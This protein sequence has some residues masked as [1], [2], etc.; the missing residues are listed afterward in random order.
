MKIILSRKGFDSG[1][2][3]IP[4]PIL[5]DGTMLSMPIPSLQ[6]G[7]RYNELKCTEN[8]SYQNI[9]EQLAVSNIKLEG[10]GSFDISSLDCHLDPDIRYETYDRKEGW[11]GI[12]GQAGS[13]L[14]HLE[15]NQVEKGDVFLFFGWFRHTVEDNGKLKYDRKCKGFH[16]IYGYL[17]VDE[18]KKI[19]S[20]E[21][22]EWALYHP[23]VRRGSSAKES[24]ALYISS[25]RLTILSNKQGYG[26]F[27]Y[28]ERLKLTKNGM[29][30]SRWILP[31]F[32]REY[33]ISYHSDQ[34]WKDGYFQSAAKGQEFVID[35]DE[36]LSKWL[37]SL[38]E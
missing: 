35:G 14:S 30:R 17:Q 15:N 2:G 25:D 13:A 32:F 20:N 4:S 6:D 37:K 8:K 19:N 24:D 27:K 18:V 31:E 9:I 23:H 10:R 29:S 3:G 28:N 1:Y 21:F 34:S 33:K 22:A 16:S 7:I 38:F 36:R 12:F 5:P 26:T 11:K